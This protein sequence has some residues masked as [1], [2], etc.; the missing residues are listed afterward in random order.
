MALVDSYGRIHDY[1]RI[2]L[3]DKCNLRC[4]YCMPSETY[5]GLPNKHLMNTEE[6]IS[7]SQT[8]IDLGVKKI[9]LT[10]GEP[11]I[12]KDIGEILVA[13][14][15]TGCQLDITSNGILL[16]HHWDH[17]KAAGIRTLNLSIDTL[18]NDRFIEIAKRDELDRVRTNIK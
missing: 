14:G 4:S 10:G 11:L 9:R 6:I 3:T 7:I 16:H 18:N 1:L 17:L 2:S 5:R 8:F 13:I 15:K 12:R